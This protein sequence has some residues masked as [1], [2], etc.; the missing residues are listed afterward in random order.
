MEGTPAAGLAAGV[1]RGEDGSDVWNTSKSSARAWAALGMGPNN[2]LLHA[3]TVNEWGK[4]RRRH[5]HESTLMANDGGEQPRAE[6][7]TG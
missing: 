1:I 3:S 6:G 2:R 5:R 4:S 7:D